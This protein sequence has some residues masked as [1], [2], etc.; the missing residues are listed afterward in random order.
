VH[1]TIV[2][3][4]ALNTPQFE[5]VKSRL[6]HKAQPVPPIFQPEVAAEAIVWAAHHHRRELWVGWPTVKAIVGEKLVPAYL[7][8]RLARTG[9][10]A[11]QTDEP[12]EPSRPDNLWEPAPGPFA[13]HGRFDSRARDWSAQLWATLHREWIVAG[14]TAVAAL[15]AGAALPLRRHPPRGRARRLARRVA[16]AVH[17]R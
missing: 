4:P 7:D 8:R 1:V 10:D 13:A 16:A 12:A 17:A 15:A 9:Y 6:P 11:Q 14:A 3:L 2:H 5:W